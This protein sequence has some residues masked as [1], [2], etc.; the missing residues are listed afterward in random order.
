M[1]SQAHTQQIIKA[2][3]KAGAMLLE[4]IE[5]HRKVSLAQA[6]SPEWLGVLTALMN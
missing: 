2:P 1:R 4:G 5:A 6:L 3:S